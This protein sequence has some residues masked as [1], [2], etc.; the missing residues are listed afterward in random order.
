MRA[1]RLHAYIEIIRGKAHIV[2]TW[3]GQ[4]TKYKELP[5]TMCTEYEET[6]AT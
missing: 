2:D 4:S 6:Y 5:I 1:V 3:S